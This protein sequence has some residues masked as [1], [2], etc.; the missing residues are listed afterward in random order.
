MKGVPTYQA[1]LV[2]NCNRLLSR[3][4]D[5]GSATAAPVGAVVDETTAPGTGV[6]CVESVTTSPVDTYP[7]A[8]DFLRCVLTN[9]RRA[10]AYGFGTGRWLQS[11]FRHTAPPCAK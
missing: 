1:P 5:R 6:S 11:A 10:S 8:V 4:R 2:R 7:C 9:L 3:S